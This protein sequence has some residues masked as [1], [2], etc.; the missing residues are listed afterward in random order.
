M[1]KNSCYFSVWVFFFLLPSAIHDWHETGDDV[2]V[3]IAS[4]YTEELIKY[5]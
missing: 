4:Q 2:G 3:F 1:I 5:F